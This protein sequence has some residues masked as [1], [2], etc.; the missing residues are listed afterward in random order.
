[1]IKLFFLLFCASFAL[2]DMRQ[3]KVLYTSQELDSVE[4]KYGSQALNRIY[5]YIK[6]VH[7]LQK[8]KSTQKIIKLND[9]LNQLQSEYDSVNQNIN[10]YWES[11]K[12]FLE[13]GYGD[14]E[15]YAIIKYYTLQTLGYS[16]KRLFFAV[17]QDMFSGSMHMILLYYPSLTKEP[18][19]LDNLSFKILK[20]SKRSD[21]EVRYIF[22]RSGAYKINHYGKIIQKL[23][24]NL[25]RFKN[26]E[27]KVAAGK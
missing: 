19:V 16:E 14:C 7:S 21:L 9:Y 8:I 2:A 3:C 25:S 11:P 4:K 15:D 24:H 20:L 1:M 27:D 12:E 23:S 5:D 13:R 17:V 22:N 18:Y 6:L 26:L 10:D